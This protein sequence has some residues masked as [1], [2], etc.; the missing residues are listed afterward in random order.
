M[1]D[2]KKGR[3]TRVLVG[4]IPV[5]TRKVIVADPAVFANFVV[6]RR[7]RGKRKRDFT[8]SGSCVAAELKLGAAELLDDDGD[9]VA[10]ATSANAKDCPIYALVR[11]GKVVRLVVVFDEDPCR[12]R[13]RLPGRK[14]R[15]RR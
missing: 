7:R 10:V 1:P 3:V 11:D 13:P 8:Y 15:R 9:P 4:R 14:K 12:E 2:G 6:D 5:F